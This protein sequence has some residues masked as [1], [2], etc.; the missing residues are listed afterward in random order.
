MKTDSIEQ[1]V[2]LRAA[3][4]K[5][6]SA[7]EERLARIN[8]ALADASGPDLAARSAPARGR[9]GRRAVRRRLRNQPSLREVVL[10]AVRSQPLTKPEIL[11]AVE[12][13]GYRFTTKNPKKSLD[14]LLYKKG[15]FRRVG[16]KFGPAR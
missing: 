5:E 14:V 7:L 15:L 10:A 3:L 11:A 9:G 1:Y 12:K 4:L 13:A 16:K 6:K 2:S 8:R